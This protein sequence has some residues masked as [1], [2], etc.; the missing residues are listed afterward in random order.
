MVEN[1]EGNLPVILPEIVESNFKD[2]WVEGLDIEKYHSDTSALSSSGIRCFASESPLS[3]FKKYISREIKIESSE[4]MEFGQKA[5][6][7]ILEPDVF[8]ER[9]VRMPDFGPMQS[10]KNREKRDAWIAEQGKDALICT[11][12]DL[13]HL[14][15]MYESIQKHR[16][17]CRIIKNGQAE[18]SGYFRHRRTN[19]KC[20]I[21]P[22]YIQKKL[23]AMPDLKTA[24]DCEFDAFRRVIETQMLDVQLAMYAEGTQIITGQK[25]EYPCWIV[26]EKVPPYSVAVWV[27][28]EAM[29]DMGL[30]TFNHALA[31]IKACMEVNFWPPY[32]T[33]AQ[34]I[35]PSMWAM[36]ARDRFLSIDFEGSLRR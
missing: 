25:I 6:V 21:R 13:I 10:P 27:A 16:D 35:G 19:L 2:Q 1:S 17:A 9:Y 12:K 36:G 24:R 15:G 34:N 30:Q 23:W 14:Q 11:E 7:C 20:R 4:E 18:L 22:D 32:Q 33:G 31:G 5:H 28:D 26:V 29:M 8:Q 3:F